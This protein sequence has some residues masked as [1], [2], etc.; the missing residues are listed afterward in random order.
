MWNVP[1]RRSRHLGIQSPRVIL[2]P[3]DPSEANGIRGYLP[4]F[5]CF[6]AVG[7]HGMWVKPTR[8]GLAFY[9]RIF[10]LVRV[11]VKDG[12]GR[13]PPTSGGRLGLRNRI[14]GNRQ[15]CSGREG[16]REGGWYEYYWAFSYWGEGLVR[17]KQISQF[18]AT[19]LASSIPTKVK[20]VFLW[21]YF[22]SVFKALAMRGTDT[23]FQ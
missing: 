3:V 8:V 19:S 18:E 15:S 10:S 21:I 12:P 16:G 11:A 17:S 2:L 7:P 22:L 20:I 23:V 6:D 9:F 14:M 4:S 13:T 5:R 1:S